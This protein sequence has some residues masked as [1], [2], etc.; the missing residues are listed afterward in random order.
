MVT[1]WLL[2]EDKGAVHLKAPKQTHQSNLLHSVSPLLLIR[3]PANCF[4]ETDRKQSVLLSDLRWGKGGLNTERLEETSGKW[5][6]LMMLYVRLISLGGGVRGSVP[7]VYQRVLFDLLLFET[8]FAWLMEVPFWTF[9]LQLF[10]FPFIV[11][12]QWSVGQRASLV[13]SPLIYEQRDNLLVVGCN[14]GHELP[15]LMISGGTWGHNKKQ[16]LAKIIVTLTMIP[17]CFCWNLNFRSS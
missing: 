14:W 15:P 16:S 17:E 6:D 10:L 2:Y 8:L 5:A 3:N 4:T 12:G 11:L 1:S 7:W 9:N 13:E